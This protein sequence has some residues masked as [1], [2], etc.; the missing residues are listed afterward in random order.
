[1]TRLLQKVEGEWRVAEFGHCMRHAQR[2][3]S[4]GVESVDADVEQRKVT[5]NGTASVPNWPA[6]SVPTLVILVCAA[7]ANVPVMEVLATSVVNVP[8]AGVEPPMTELFT[9]PATIVRALAT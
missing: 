9:V 4:T 1:M 6:T 8:A 2:S 3:S 5:V 7:V